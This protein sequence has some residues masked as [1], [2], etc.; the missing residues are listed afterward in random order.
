MHD[1]LQV[2]KRGSQAWAMAAKPRIKPSPKRS[3]RPSNLATL[4]TPHLAAQRCAT[5]VAAGDFSLPAQP[6][7][8]GLVFSAE[9]QQKRSVFS[10]KKT[11]GL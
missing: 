6:N 9:A 8:K 11:Q 4:K 1:L 2:V 3:G 10:K 5:L 7:E